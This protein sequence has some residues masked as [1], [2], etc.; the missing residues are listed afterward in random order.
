[1]IK[2]LQL[3]VDRLQKGED[4]YILVKDLERRKA[5]KVQQ[6]YAN[7][8]L[9]PLASSLNND[10]T[11]IERCK[12][13]A[14]HSSTFPPLKIVSNDTKRIESLVETGIVFCTMPTH[15]LIQEIQREEELA[16]RRNK[17]D[18]FSELDPFNE[19]LLQSLER[20]LNRRSDVQ[21]KEKESL[22]RESLKAIFDIHV[23]EEK[24][25]PNKI[26][27]Y[28]VKRVMDLWSLVMAGDSFA[29]MH[30]LDNDYA[31]HSDLNSADYRIHTTCK[32]LSRTPLH[33]AGYLGE[34]YCC[35][36]LLLRGA[37]VDQLDD[38]G[39][40]ALDLALIEGHR[41]CVELLIA[42]GADCI[43]SK[44]IPIK[45]G[46]RW[47]SCINVIERC[48]EFDR[49]KNST[50]ES[51][52]EENQ[53]PGQPLITVKGEGNHRMIYDSVRKAGQPR[54]G[55]IYIGNWHV[56]Q[57]K[58][59]E[60]NEDNQKLIRV[61]HTDE[62]EF[63]VLWLPKSVIIGK[64]DS[65]YP[66]WG[67][68]FRLSD[69]QALYHGNYTESQNLFQTKKH[70]N[71][72]ELLFVDPFKPVEKE[73]QKKETHTKNGYLIRT[74]KEK[75]KEIIEEIIDW[76]AL[77]R[78]DV[79][80]TYLYDGSYL[81]G[82][83]HGKGTLFVRCILQE[84]HSVGSVSQISKQKHTRSSIKKAEHGEMWRPYYRGFF[85]NG[86]FEG[87]GCLWYINFH[88]KKQKNNKIMYKGNFSDGVPN[89]IGTFYFDDT[90]EEKTTVTCTNI[91]WLSQHQIVKIGKHQGLFKNGMSH[92][93][94]IS[95]YKENNNKP[96]QPFINGKF[97]QGLVHGNI[98]IYK[99]DGNTLLYSGG[100]KNGRLHGIGTRIWADSIYKGDF[101]NGQPEGVGQVETTDGTI[102]NGEFEKG[103]IN[104]PIL[105][106]EW[107]EDSI[108]H[109]IA[110]GGRL[111]EDRLI[112]KEFFREL[113][114]IRTPKVLGYKTALHVAVESGNLG[115]VM[116]LVSRGACD[117]QKVDCLNRTALDCAIW[118]NKPKAR[119]FLEL[120]KVVHICRKK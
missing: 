29:L 93:K 74:K 72:K 46:R 73:I 2:S 87:E 30:V 44:A 61:P 81:N 85:K 14:L 55:N 27:K 48:K 117:P 21:I 119:A 64:F 100:S 31:S 105:K 91:P 49:N 96:W 69:G 79:K 62:D 103:C 76:Y 28:G 56:V 10:S 111:L 11:A 34:T 70:G 113:T 45:S 59:N 99:S 5:N 66:R 8:T 67:T 112:S 97:K 47:T 80:V 120:L 71:G 88:S 115:S 83:F 7:R 35:L 50:V 42:F 20:E 52:E 68:E 12:A 98:K 54:I 82:L 17:P 37:K 24:V 109:D 3:V 118:S 33:V 107:N 36:C 16:D 23:K 77:L 78:Q 57:E 1:M 75:K 41:K 116:S 104:R 15:C 6:R 19:T 9:P 38:D 39:Y 60:I 101:V 43:F 13:M 90:F 94:G 102:I 86:A 18:I 26:L 22:E 108:F 65:G 84:E 32:G 106:K 114:K 63:G 89:G 110:F 53:R 40:T 95:Y 51:K 25:E 92:G 58:Q 4:N